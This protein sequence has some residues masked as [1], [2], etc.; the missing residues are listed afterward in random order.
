MNLLMLVSLPL[1]FLGQIHFHVC[2]LSFFGPLSFLLGSAED[3]MP[4]LFL[5]RFGSVTLVPFSGP[6]VI[7]PVRLSSPSWQVPASA[8]LKAGDSCLPE[9]V[10]RSP[11]VGQLSTMPWGVCLTSLRFLMGPRLQSSLPLCELWRSDWGFPCKDP[12]DCSQ[13]GS[14]VHGTSIHSLF[15]GLFPIQGSNPGLSHHRQILCHLSPPGK[16]KDMSHKWIGSL[17]SPPEYLSEREAPAPCQT[18]GRELVVRQ[19]SYHPQ[20]L[21]HGRGLDPSPSLPGPVLLGCLL[22][23]YFSS[24]N[25]LPRNLPPTLSPVLGF[26]FV[27]CFPPCSSTC[28]HH[29]ICLL[30]ISRL[31]WKLLENRVFTPE[32]KT[33]P[34]WTK[35]ALREK[36]LNES[37][38]QPS[39]WTSWKGLW[40]WPSPFLKFFTKGNWEQS[41][42]SKWLLRFDTGTGLCV[43]KVLSRHTIPIWLPTHSL[44]IIL[45]VTMESSLE[46]LSCSGSHKQNLNSSVSHPRT[47]L[48]TS[49]LG[50]TNIFD[51][52]RQVWLRGMLPRATILRSQATSSFCRKMCDWLAI[53]PLTQE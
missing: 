22:T 23:G 4:S 1:W 5:P 16:P 17:T 44:K 8:P 38:K 45:V 14:F 30:F 31:E 28:W 46:R 35:V 27:F 10:L 53:V 52:K 39:S 47:L 20:V 19:S 51:F 32:P 34:P 13:P 50:V 48:Y 43:F 25:L 7:S 29:T 2:A 33:E 41:R 11:T 26:C 9:R 21:W 24:Q 15:E 42:D 3:P 18:V 6:P 36:P 49:R 37:V 40:R 12:M